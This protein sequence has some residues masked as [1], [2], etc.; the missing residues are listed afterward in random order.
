MGLNDFIVHRVPFYFASF[1]IGNSCHVACYRFF[2][3][4]VYIAARLPA[5]PDTVKP[6]FDMEMSCINSPSSLK[7]VH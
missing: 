4:A 5:I 3:A 2:E 7:G 1:Q 6:F